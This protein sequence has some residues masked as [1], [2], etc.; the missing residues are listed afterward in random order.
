MDCNLCGNGLCV[1]D[2]GSFQPLPGGVDCG[3]AGGDV[4]SAARDGAEGE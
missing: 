4:L 3:S 2:G 1:A